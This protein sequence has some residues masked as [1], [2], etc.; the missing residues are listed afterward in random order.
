MLEEKIEKDI[1]CK[2]WPKENWSSYINTKQDRLRKEKK[3][4]R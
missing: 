1:P 3:Y 4:Q 2:H